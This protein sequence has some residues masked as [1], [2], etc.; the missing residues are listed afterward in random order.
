MRK[1]KKPIKF[2]LF[3]FALTSMVIGGYT[4]YLMIQ[5]DIQE[6]DLLNLFLLP[7]SFTMMYYIFDSIMQKIADRKKKTDFESLFL[8]EVGKRLTAANTFLIED[9]RKL[10]TNTKFQESLKIAYAIFDKGETP[11]WTIEKLERRFDKR[12]IEAKAMIII[13]DYIKE[14]Q[15]LG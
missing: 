3:L 7:P 4:V 15:N 9:F 5:G 1:Y 13:V 8:E 14:K 10:Q 11:D 6:R 2:Y 12:S